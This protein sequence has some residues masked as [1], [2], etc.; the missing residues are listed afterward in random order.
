MRRRRFNR[1]RWQLERERHQIAESRPPPPLTDTPVAAV[2]TD[3]MHRLGG[4]DDVWLRRME[5]RWPS[6]V[7]EA[8]AAHS[9]PGRFDRGTLTVFVDNSVW[10]SELTRFGQREILARVQK[11]F[12]DQRIRNLRFQLDPDRHG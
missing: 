6:L 2:I 4:G 11:D 7:G 1:G 9:R 3:L 8:V 5:A 10:L 12:P